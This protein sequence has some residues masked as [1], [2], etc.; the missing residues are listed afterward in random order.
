MLARNV[1]RRTQPARTVTVTYSVYADFPSIYVAE[2]LRGTRR[3][4][5]CGAVTSSLVTLDAPASEPAD[6][7]GEAAEASGGIAARSAGWSGAIA[8]AHR[9]MVAAVTGR[10][11]RASETDARLAGHVADSWAT[12]RGGRSEASELRAGAAEVPAR[13][14]PWVDLPAG[15]LR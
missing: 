9:D 1:V 3:I 6:R 10:L 13:L 5:D 8:S 12:H 4:A 2:S 14:G 7:I 15:E 11:E